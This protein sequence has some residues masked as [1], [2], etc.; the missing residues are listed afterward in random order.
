MDAIFIAE[1]DGARTYKVLGVAK[2]VQK[3]GSGPKMVASI[4]ALRY[5]QGLGSVLLLERRELIRD[6]IEGLAPRYLLPFPF[7]PSTDTFQGMFQLIRVIEPFGRSG[8]PRTNEAPAD[9]V[10]GIP[11][12]LRDLAVLNVNQDPTVVMAEKT[13]GFFIVVSESIAIL[14]LY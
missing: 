14:P 5:N 13:G 8:G 4:G 11:R 10:I 12:Y 7:S 3:P 9:G 2:E 1:A 6:F